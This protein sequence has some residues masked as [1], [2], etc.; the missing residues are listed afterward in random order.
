MTASF[1]DYTSEY[2]H[3]GELCLL[4]RDGVGQGNY[5][6]QVYYWYDVWLWESADLQGHGSSD[7][8]REA[9]GE[10]RKY[11]KQNPIQPP[12]CEVEPTEEK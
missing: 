1:R 5:L 9:K 7:T 12:P 4:I 10:L 3:R 11:L 8:R 2:G 6:G